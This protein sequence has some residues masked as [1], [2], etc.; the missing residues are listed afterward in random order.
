MNRN[1]TR[2][3]I[4]LVFAAL[5]MITVSSAQSAESIW[6]SGHEDNAPAANFLNG[7]FCYNATDNSENIFLDNGSGKV[8]EAT[9]GTCSL[10]DG[11]SYSIWFQNNGSSS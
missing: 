11:R 1:I 10:T 2:I 9:P 6:F 5:F 3:R 4:V 8:Q 7:G